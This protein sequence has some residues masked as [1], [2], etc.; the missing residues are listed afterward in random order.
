MKIYCVSR[1]YLMLRAVTKAVAT[2]A[3]GFVYVQ[4]VTHPTPM[5]ARLALLAGFGLFGWL[6]YV[7]QPRMPIEISLAEDGEVSFRGRKGEMHVKASDI[8]SIRPGLG[9]RTV[10]V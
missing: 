10:R 4:A 9:R 1:P 8:R 5:P 6:L 7:R 2:L 3:A